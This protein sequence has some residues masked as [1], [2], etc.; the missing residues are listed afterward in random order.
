MLEG[1]LIALIT[2]LAVIVAVKVLYI[3]VLL[4]AMLI[5]GIFRLTGLLFRGVYLF[6][7]RPV[8][9]IVSHVITLPFR[10][11]GLILRPMLP[12][13]ASGVVLATACR[14]GACQCAN[15]AAARFCR[16]CGVTIAAG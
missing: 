10:L 5:S 8:F 12:A 15:P 1:L 11:A 9:W 4:A 13:A 3:L 7:L 2:V 16:R 6:V 14:N